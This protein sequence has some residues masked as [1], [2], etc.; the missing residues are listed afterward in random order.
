MKTPTLAFA[1][2]AAGLLFAG[3]VPAAAA[4]AQKQGTSMS[5]GDLDLNTAAG[6]AELNQRFDQAAREK[7]GVV[8]G[9]KANA[10]ARYCYKTTGEQYRHY[11]AALLAQH[12]RAENDKR[13]GLAAR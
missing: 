8:E 13:F 10:K 12:D 3:T 7:C 1:A 6:R 9:R 4:D 2:I 11:A 5:Y